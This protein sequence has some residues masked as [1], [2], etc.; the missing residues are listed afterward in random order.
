MSP[1]Q[2]IRRTAGSLLLAA[3]LATTLAL[4][5]CGSRNDDQN[6]VKV[7]AAASLKSAFSELANPFDGGKVQLQFAGSDALAAQIRNGTKPALF[8]AANTKLP[9]ELHAEG[10]LEQ[11]VAFTTNTLVIA[12]QKDSDKIKSID[13][14]S[15]AGV[16][17]AVGAASV[18]VGSYTRKV[19]GGL[20]AAERKAVIRNFRSEEPDVKGVVGKV[21]NGAVD[22]GFVYITDVKAAEDQLKAIA[23]PAQIKPEVVYSAGVVKGADP[24]GLGQQFLDLL[25][26]P[27]GQQ[28]LIK[29][30]FGPAP[31]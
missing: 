8:A 3:L 2:M 21:A 12:V 10:L 29:A 16:K 26:S 7:S 25:L 20:P 15:R 22:A 14:L 18:P 23:L 5:G 17:I 1:A 31:S 13:D 11:P 6:T 30:G 19:L 24:D 9:D 4:A 28:A 27:A